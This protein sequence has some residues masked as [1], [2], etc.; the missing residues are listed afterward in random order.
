M[1]DV[2]A[3]LEKTAILFLPEAIKFNTLQFSGAGKLG[4]NEDGCIKSPK[5]LPSLVKFFASNE[6]PPRGA[7]STG[8]SLHACARGRHEELEACIVPQ[9]RRVAPVSALGDS[10]R[11]N[12]F[13]P[14]TPAENDRLHMYVRPDSRLRTKLDYNCNL[15]VL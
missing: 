15:V 10:C 9:D 14:A 13:F 11:Q 6:A 7:H 4:K 3:G 1:V 8:S 2:T 5:L 12:P